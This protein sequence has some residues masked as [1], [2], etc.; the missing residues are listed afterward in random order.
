MKVGIVVPFSWSFW[1]AVNEHAEL[2]AEALGRLGIE[3]RTHHRQRS[4]GNVH[5]G[6]APPPRAARRAAGRRD[7]RR[8][9]GDRP[10]QRLAAE[11][12]PHAASPGP[13]CGAFSRRERFDV[14]HLHEPMTPGICVSAL[15]TAQCPVV[16][17]WHAAGELNWHRFGLPLWGFLIDRIDYRIAV[18]EQ[19]RHLG[20]ALDAR[21]LRRHPQRRARAAG[22]GLREPRPHGRVHRP[23]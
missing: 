2:Q 3:T 17:T 23:P 21:R 6:A 10:G 11:H 13:V 15:A 19:A 1:G 16:A 4:A 7:P 8:P 20:V 5:A 22:G 9:V 18:S 14:I 12:R